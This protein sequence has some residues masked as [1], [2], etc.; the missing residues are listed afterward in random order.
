LRDAI[1]RDARRAGEARV[2]TEVVA[3]AST[4]LAEGQAA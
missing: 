3:R 1:E 2:T 4:M